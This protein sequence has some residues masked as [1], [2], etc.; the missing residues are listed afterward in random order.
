MERYLDALSRSAHLNFSY[1]VVTTAEALKQQFESRPWDLS[2][3]EIASNTDIDSLTQLILPHH[4]PVFCTTNEIPLHL[5][6]RLM[7]AGVK[8]VI[9]RHNLTYMAE[10][11]SEELAR[12]EEE[13]G[14]TEQHARESEARYRIV[15]QL[16][17]DSALQYDVDDDGQLTQVWA[18]GADIDTLLGHT[19]RDLSTISKRVSYV[20]PD[21]REAV[22]RALAQTL[23]GHEATNEYR[24]KDSSGRYRWFLGRRKPLWDDTKQKVTGFMLALKETTARKEAEQ[25]LLE[26][27][28]RYRAISELMSD[29]TSQISA[30]ESGNLTRVLWLG[31]GLG[32]LLGYESGELPIRLTEGGD[33]YHPDDKAHV[34]K[35]IEQTMAGHETT[36]EHRLRSHKGDYHWFR[37]SRKPIWNE[38]HTKVTGY[39]IGLKNINAQ[40]KAELAL[41]ESE[42]QY[43]AI[44]EMMSD[45]A[46]LFEVDETGRATRILALGLDFFDKL[47]RTQASHRSDTDIFQLIHPD[48]VEG[49]KEAVQRTIAGY[50]TANEY[51]MR[52][53]DGSYLWFSFRRRPIWNKARTRVTHF[54]SATK[55]I[56]VAKE[57]ERALRESEQRHRQMFER[58]R[59]PKL[60]IDPSCGE[61]LDANSAAIDFYGYPWSKLK[62]MHISKINQATPEEVAIKM[63]Q[64]MRGERN[65]CI[66]VQ[67]TADGTL[68]DM[69]VYAGGITWGD[70]KALYAIYIDVTERNRAQQALERANQELELRV[71]QR[72]QQLEQV[73]NQIEAIFN[74]SGDGILLLNQTLH[75]VEANQT[76][77]KLVAQSREHYVNQPLTGYLSK[78]DTK[79]LTQAVTDLSHT[80]ETQQVELQL[81][82]DKGAFTAEVNLS[83]VLTEL[84]ANKNYVLTIR[85]IT[86][87]KKAEEQL[88]YLASLQ[89]QMQDAVVS[90]DI[91]FIVRSWNGAAVHMYGWETEEALGKPFSELIKTTFP[92]GHDYEKAMARL[93]A[94]GFVRDEVIQYHRNGTP[95]HALRSIA[96][97]RDK[98]G[99]PIGFVGVN[100]DISER[101]AAEKELEII[102]QRLQLATEAG[103]LGIWEWNL[104]TDL[105]VWDKQMCHLYGISPEQKTTR[106]SDWLACI[107]PDDQQQAKKRFS[108]ALHTKRPFYH[109]FRTVAPNGT[110]RHILA[111]ANIYADEHEQIERMVGVNMEITDLK[112]AENALRSALESEQ[113]LSELKTQIVSVA[114]HEFRTP[115]TTILVTAETLLRYRGRM[116]DEKIDARLNKIVYQVHHMKHLTE[117]MLQLAR[118]QAG[119]QEFQPQMGDLEALCRDVVAEF[120]A[121]EKYKGRIDYTS[122]VAPIKI[123]FDHKLIRQSINNLLH[124]G[125]KY[126][127]EET[128]VNVHLS[129][130]GAQVSLQIK[131]RGIGIPQADRKRLFDPFHRASNVGAISGTGLGLSITKSAIDAHGGEIQLISDVGEGATFTILLPKKEEILVSHV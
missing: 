3:W 122:N 15:S 108:Q 2:I 40:K 94:D 72:T 65:S 128:A 25:S 57:A 34:L 11:L 87:R 8:A 119:K 20:H 93:Y 26:S 31:T 45:S 89:A 30:D 22:E 52:K 104:Q 42:T 70:Q 76:F 54:M 28:E 10:I 111:Q 83:P 110:I 120:E 85:D 86:Q 80:Q 124:N 125:L 56:T 90:I 6:T 92:K 74:N 16:M 69:E 118:L 61:I 113:E 127:E 106:F 116:D 91:D 78:K 68:Y 97:N 9:E 109:Q 21:D 44:S 66:F 98:A 5:A 38:Q 100:R 24:L 73:K 60:I 29:Y 58:V 46:Y 95:F 75:V 43:R 33:F 84:G 48:D 62:G 129:D 121:H 114:S 37:S 7:R 17:S 101:K 41:R 102:S 77:G 63:G 50:E 39:L 18:V 103:H 36:D 4:S 59:L 81:S 123:V 126:S 19:D 1:T 117:D 13:K 130:N 107:H 53:T 47:G 23:A 64:I 27:E 131:D 96:L 99:R 71:T 49:V 88:H 12:G 105:F 14:N 51:R 115:L 112:Q 55:D 82:R 67:K 35:A 32:K 79:K